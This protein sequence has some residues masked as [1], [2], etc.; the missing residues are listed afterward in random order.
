MSF[1]RKS[2]AVDSKRLDT[3]FAKLCDETIRTKELAELDS[4]LASDG[5][6]R[7]YY[8]RYMNLH[9]AL[10]TYLGKEFEKEAELDA[11]DAGDPV[12]HAEPVKARH[13]V[14]LIPPAL[15][16]PI[17]AQ[18]RPR[19]NPVLLAAAAMVVFGV[20]LLAVQW[21]Y[22][23]VPLSGGSGH[24]YAVLTQ[25]IDAKWAPGSFVPKEGKAIGNEKLKLASGAVR[26][27]FGR[28]AD[29]VFAEEA[30]IEILTDNSVRLNAGKMFAE[31]PAS[32]SGFTVDAG[33]FD[34]IDIGTV[35]GVTIGEEGDVEVSVISGNVELA[36][37]DPET[38]NQVRI[39]PL[40]K[41]Q[42][43]VARPDDLNVEKR[44]FD[45]TTYAGMRLSGQRSES[46]DP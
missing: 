3:L 22:E 45:V 30:E 25:V 43:V 33:A 31:V 7:R 27:N 20:G 34:V 13:L 23:K 6:A 26:M 14:P 21:L 18:P 17:R 28:G 46:V 24:Q 15:E 44:R 39:L 8:R 38:G 40:R 5:A 19:V 12:A 29:V 10:H 2:S 1:S 32:A 16:G 42:S 36:V 41:W 11:V 37:K 9:A 35:F 4:A